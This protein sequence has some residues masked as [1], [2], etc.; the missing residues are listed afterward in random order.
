[1]L[2]KSPCWDVFKVGG[3]FQKEVETK[4]TKPS[5]IQ[6]KKKSKMFTKEVTLTVVSWTRKQLV[7]H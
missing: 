2:T 6:V 5:K 1:M 3:Q 7:F 4:S